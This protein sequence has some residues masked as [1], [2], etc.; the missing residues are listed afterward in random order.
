[1]CGIAGVIGALNPDL[2][3]RLRAMTD[4][5]VHRG[6]DSAGFFSTGQGPGV[7]F[8]FRRLAILDLRPEGNQPMIDEA[9]RNVVV[10]NG[11]IYNYAALREELGGGGAVF[12]T[13]TDT[14]VLLAAY[15]RWG[16]EAVGRLRGM[17]AFA[18]YDAE[19]RTVLLA[20]D[21]LGIKPLYY[22]VLERPEGRVMLFASE[23]RALLATELFDRHLDP[24]GL[25]TYLW[26]GFVVGPN[27]LVRGISLLLPGALLMVRID[28]PE[29]RPLRYWSLRERAAVS[30]SDAVENVRRELATATRQHLV[31]DVPLGIFLSGGVDSSAVAALAVAA[32]SRKVQTFH[33]GF[34]EPSYD[35]SRYAR[36][37]AGALGT[38]HVELTLTQQRF[39]EQLDQALASLDQ[40]TF[41]AINT[42]FVSRLVREAGFT[43]ALAGTGGDELFGGYRSFRELPPAR[44][45][46]RALRFLPD[47]ALGAAGRL[48]A[49]FKLGPFGEVPPQTRWG[50]LPDLLQARGD[51][52]RLYQVSYGLFT[53]DFLRELAAPRTW[54]P[55]G[56]PPERAEELSDS[57]ADATPLGAVSRLELGLFIG[58]RLLRDSDT[59]SMATSLELRVPLLDHGVVEAVQAVP[60]EP[61]YL[62]LGRKQLLRSLA[63]SGID[64][65][66]FDRPKSGFVLPIEVWAKDRLSHQIAESF[67][68][69]ALVEG[70]GLRSEPLGRLWRSFQ[71]G[72]PGFYWSRIWAPYVL[73]DWC[74]RHRMSMA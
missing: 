17:F 38:E 50:K 14:E 70:A 36:A 9:R 64:R 4:A 73:L 48:G 68:N 10:F 13:A 15:G 43:V 25:G 66:L 3:S 32:G 71:S 20:R 58:E 34:E 23:L 16:E 74:R 65:A 62:P 28:A 45:V 8:G 26:N 59:A 42:Y 29:P 22:A 69:R 53:R 56:L 51:T 61:R 11:E 19:R 2:D 67:A 63:L 7:A 24:T 37:V 40:P 55:N 12:R 35:E 72:A 41:D 21:R 39:R 54:V 31:S 30:A 5:Q 47:R 49:R 6:P 52:L 18:I 46:T 27:T 60:D 44:R 33:I 1:M 57:I